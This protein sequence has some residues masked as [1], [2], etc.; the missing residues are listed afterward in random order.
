MCPSFSVLAIS[1]RDPCLIHAWSMPENG[2]CKWP[3]FGQSKW[4]ARHPWRRPQNGIF[5]H[6]V[7]IVWVLTLRLQDTRSGM[8]LTLLMRFGTCWCFMT[9]EQNKLASQSL[10]HSCWLPSPGSFNLQVRGMFEEIG[11]F[12]DFSANIGDNLTLEETKLIYNQLPVELS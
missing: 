11:D 10:F 4:A 6:C 2:N 9:P 12:L 1:G 7:M 5:A 8:P 3:L